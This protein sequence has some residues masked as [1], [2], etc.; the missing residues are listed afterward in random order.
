A[1]HSAG[2]SIPPIHH[3]GVQLD[4]AVGVQARADAGVEERLIL[5]VAD[6]GDSCFERAAADALPARLERALDRGLPI[7][8]LGRRNRAGAAVDDEGRPAHTLTLTLR[9][10]RGQDA[11]P[12]L[13]LCSRSGRG[14]R[15]TRAGTP[16]FALF[17][18]RL[19]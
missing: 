6:R 11:L 12:A 13:N 7:R 17:G 14:Q 3:A 19:R 10:R 4:H 15:T 18:A 9:A 8:E 5:H 2:A 1:G 16:G